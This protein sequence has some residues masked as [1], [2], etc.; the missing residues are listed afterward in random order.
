MKIALPN[1]PTPQLRPRGRAHSPCV[2]KLSTPLLAD[3]SQTV[4]RKKQNIAVPAVVIPS[5]HRWTTTPST[6]GTSLQRPTSSA[7]LQNK[8]H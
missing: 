4:G 6:R 3:A 2:S 8:T 1:P 5:D 7:P